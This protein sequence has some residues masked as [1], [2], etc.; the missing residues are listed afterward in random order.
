[1]GLSCGLMV[2]MYAGPAVAAPSRFGFVVVDPRSGPPTT[3]IGVEYRQ[4]NAGM[5]CRAAT[6][7]FKWDG[8]NVAAAPMGHNC[9][10]K[11]AFKPPRDDRSP[12]A[13][14][15]SAWEG[16]TALGGA[17]FFVTAGSP[18]PSPSSSPS[19]DPSPSPSPSKSK[20][21]KPS[22]SPSPEET[23]VDPPLP[24]ETE[25]SIDGTIA[26]AGP[27]AA[28]QGGS[29]SGGGG[30]GPI[31]VALAFGGALVLGGVA[32]LGFIVFRGRRDDTEPEPAILGDSPTQP[33]P[34]FGGLFATPQPAA[35]L[36][37]T[38]EPALPPPVPD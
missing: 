26:A 6:I 38:V 8:H 19:A 27:P 3:T 20:G 28:G 1:M 33:I 21:A 10:A 7:T 5:A 32:I 29:E 36:P 4:D 31:G 24:T 17:L 34:T 13:H 18:S 37:T 35:G 11:S 23:E 9:V 12:G 25:P 16:G 30:M 14:Q 22:A 15:V 2:A